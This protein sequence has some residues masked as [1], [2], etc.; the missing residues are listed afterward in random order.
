MGLLAGQRRR[1]LLHDLRSHMRLLLR[2][3]PGRDQ[4]VE[5]VQLF[6]PDARPAGA[7]PGRATLVMMDPSA[8]LGDVRLR[9]GQLYTTVL[10]LADPANRAD[11]DAARAVGRA[12]LAVAAATGGTCVDL[13]GFRVLQP[14]DLV[15]R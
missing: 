1:R 13:L 15:M 3:D 6:D 11:L 14:D 2:E 12:A 9:S 5:L 4:M 10:R 7:W 8:A